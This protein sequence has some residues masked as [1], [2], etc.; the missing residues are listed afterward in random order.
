M[1]DNHN[2][3]KVGQPEAIVAKAKTKGTGYLRSHSPKAK[4][5]PSLLSSQD[6]ITNIEEKEKPMTPYLD[7]T[8]VENNI[9]QPNNSTLELKTEVKKR[10]PKTIKPATLKKPIQEVHSEEVKE[11]SIDLVNPSTDTLNEKTITTSPTESSTVRKFEKPNPYKKNF[12]KPDHRDNNRFEHKK[13]NHNSSKNYQDKNKKTFNNQPRELT[14]N[15]KAREKEEIALE[16]ITEHPPVEQVLSLIRQRTGFMA[17]HFWNEMD[18]VQASD[19]PINLNEESARILTYAVLFNKEEIYSELFEKYNEYLVP[20]DFHGHLIPYCS[21]KSSLFLDK[22]IMWY[23]KL[24]N[25]KEKLSNLLID[26]LTFCSFRQENNFIWLSW[27]EKN[28]NDE[29]LE[30]FW[31]KVF[32]FHNSVLI[33]EALNFKNLAT[34]LKN[35]L[36]RFSSF[37]D[38]CPKTHQIYSQ[39]AKP[40]YYVDRAN[41]HLETDFVQQAKDFECALLSQV[42]DKKE[43]KEEKK[44]ERREETATEVIIKKKKIIEPNL[45]QNNNSASPFL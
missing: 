30:K 3:D 37:I 23:D 19:K 39:L 26:K 4:K 42:K 5:V 10:K 32:E 11:T 2:A 1:N 27:L 24:F 31:Q 35:N 45:S 12:N 16:I 44:T 38:A 25:D 13:P 9:K 36:E 21:T 15:E 40:S 41:Q 18:L 43:H 6:N 22:T 7:E 33:M 8:N 28:S 17:S 29:I 14:A 20:D 34:Y